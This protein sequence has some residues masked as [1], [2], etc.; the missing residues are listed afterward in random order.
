MFRNKNFIK[1]TFQISKYNTIL[2][3]LLSAVDSSKLKIRQISKKI[4]LWIFQKCYG[5]GHLRNHCFLKSD[6]FSA[7]G[8]YV[9]LFTFF[10]IF[11]FFIHLFIYTFLWLA[12]FKNI[13]KKS[14]WKSRLPFTFSPVSVINVNLTLKQRTQ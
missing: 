13:I 10:K 4:H 3:L 1:V 2:E 5:F 7:G 8:K 14:F 6:W 12:T 9:K 11:E